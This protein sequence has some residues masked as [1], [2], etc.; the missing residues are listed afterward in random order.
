V[1]RPDGLPV[2]TSAALPGRLRDLTCAQDLGVTAALNCAGSELDL[3]TLADSGYEG[4]GLGSKPRPNTQPTAS[5]SRSPTGCYA[6]C[7]DKANEAS[8]PGHLRGRF[9][10]FP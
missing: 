3:P 9:V 6:A 5:L 10:S 7:T 2:W 1:I 4:A 8:H